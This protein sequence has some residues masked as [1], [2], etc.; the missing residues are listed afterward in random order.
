MKLNTML[1]LHNI[2]HLVVPYMALYLTP[3][4]ITGMQ[5]AFWEYHFKIYLWS[6]C[7]VPVIHGNVCPHFFPVWSAHL[8]HVHVHDAVTATSLWTCA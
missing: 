7:V 3:T 5:A 8:L 6:L 2:K 1:I 4:H